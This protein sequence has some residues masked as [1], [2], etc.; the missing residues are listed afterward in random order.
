M[1]KGSPLPPLPWTLALEQA[2]P[3]IRPWSSAGTLFLTAKAAMGRRSM[4]P[5]LLLLSLT[6]TPLCRA[7]QGGR[8]ATAFH[9]S[10]GGYDNYVH[11]DST[12]SGEQQGLGLPPGEVAGAGCRPH[13]ADWAR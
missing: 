8:E 12:A 4:V 11:A 7:Q 6:A 9:V 13:Q 1:S 10:Y 3:W 5:L 2:K